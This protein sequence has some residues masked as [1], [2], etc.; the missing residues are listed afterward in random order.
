MY[1][2]E[3]GDHTVRMYRDRQRDLTGHH[4]TRAEGPG[5]VAPRD[6]GG[7]HPAALT[8]DG[9]VAGTSLYS[10]LVHGDAPDCSLHRDGIATIHRL[11]RSADSPCQRPLETRGPPDGNAALVPVNPAH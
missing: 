1:D 6:A 4:D 3:T 8:A 10:P 11:H 2:Q 5:A 9:W 7:G